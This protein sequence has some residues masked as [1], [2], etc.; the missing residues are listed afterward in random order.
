MS[1]TIFSPKLLNRSPSAN[2]FQ[3][4]PPNGSLQTPPRC[5][6]ATPPKG[7]A[8]QSY[9][10]AADEATTALLMSIESENAILNTREEL[11]MSPK[12]LRC[13]QRESTSLRD[14]MAQREST[15]AQEM[16]MAHASQVKDLKAQ[17]KMLSYRNDTLRHKNR[18]AEE[19]E[20]QYEQAVQAV[21]TEQQGIDVK[22]TRIKELKRQLERYRDL[23]GSLPKS[24]EADAPEE[25]TIK[26]G[27][28]F[29]EKD[30]PT[31]GAPSTQDQE[32]PAAP[33]QGA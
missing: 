21:T 14:S 18:A 31:P 16:R 15:H 32:P 4:S 28:W 13:I 10:N 17:I 26:F 20:G 23:Y 6:I 11:R 12:E 3:P 30:D 5:L 7:E 22:M 24:E 1:A 8:T 2:R 25:P 27:G 9:A 33:E 29:N 19:V